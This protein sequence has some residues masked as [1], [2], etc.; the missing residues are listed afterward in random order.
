MEPVAIVDFACLDVAPVAWTL[1]WTSPSPGLRRGGGRRALPPL[2]HLSGGK[3][4]GKMAQTTDNA[5]NIR[6]GTTGRKG[7]IS[8]NSRTIPARMFAAE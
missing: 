3:N 4:L 6:T 8:H 7:S 5:N 2:R 1:T